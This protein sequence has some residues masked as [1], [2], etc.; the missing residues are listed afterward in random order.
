[1]SDKNA[2]D[3]RVNAHNWNIQATYDITN[4]TSVYGRANPSRVSTGVHVNIDTGGN[5][6][7]GSCVIL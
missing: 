5:H 3:F 6:K 2:G 1:M 7:S 4:K